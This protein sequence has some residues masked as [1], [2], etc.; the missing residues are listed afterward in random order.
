[1]RRFLGALSAAAVGILASI[2][3]ATPAAADVDDFTFDSMTV[4]YTLTRADDGTSRLEV[5]EEFVA[6]FPDA[7]QNRGMRRAIPDTYNGQPLKPRLVSITDGEGNARAAESDSEDGTFVMTSRA[8]DYVHGAQT[9]AFTYTLENVTWVFRDTG[10]EFNW[11]VNGVDWSQPFGDVTARLHLD[12]ELAD[13]LT[14]KWACY[15]GPQGAKQSCDS[16]DTAPA[17]GGGVTLTATQ[18]ELAPHETLTVA[19]GFAD[20]TFTLFDTSFLATPAGWVQAA[21]GIAALGAGGLALWSRRKYLRDEPGR[22]TIIAEYTP[23]PGMD[24][25]ESAVLLHKTSKAIPAEVLEQAVVGSIRIVE[26][27]QKFWGGSKL[28]AEL[29]DPSRADGDGRMLLDGLFPEGVPGAQYTFGSQ[30]QRLSKVAQSIVK[31]AE[32]ELKN[33][34]LRRTVP[35][36]ARVVPMITAAIAAAIIFIAGAIALDGGASAAW[37]V[38]LMVVGGVICAAAMLSVL[39]VPLTS[40]GSEVRDHLKGLQE[41]IEWAEADRIRMLQSP[42]GAERRPVDTRNPRQMLHMYES[43]LPYAVV[44][45]Q[46]KEWAAHLA[47]LYAANRAAGPV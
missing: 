47:V 34:G 38:V 6:R 46:E 2:A 26:G 39:S 15:A 25:L 29:V 43:L 30:D 40:A 21:G 4:D 12:A 24:A 9:Y 10:L 22:P 28:I 41:F 18:R 16:I 42:A 33:R 36:T 27:P 13:Q 5:V 11:D 37:P 7:D 19:A 17:D 35:A 32:Q 1:M 23:P 45:G 20:D 31:A 44:F 3:L 14:G 8:D